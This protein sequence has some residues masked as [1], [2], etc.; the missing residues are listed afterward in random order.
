MKPETRLERLKRH[1]EVYAPPKRVS[2]K[3]LWWR[4]RNRNNP[5]LYP[6]RRFK[7]RMA[8]IRATESG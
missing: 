8:M 2:L 3:F 1:C 6:S 5:D 4:W 7:L